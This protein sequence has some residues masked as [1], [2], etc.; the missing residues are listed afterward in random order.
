M[1]TRCDWEQDCVDGDK[2]VG[3]P[4]APSSTDGIIGLLRPFLAG[5]LAATTGP[6]SMKIV[7]SVTA[8][9]STRVRVTAGRVKV[10]P[11]FIV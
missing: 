11:S 4:I 8:P 9:F 3:V 10:A 2:E 1:F 6:G 7:Y 5:Q